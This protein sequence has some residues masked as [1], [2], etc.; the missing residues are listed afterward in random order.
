[1]ERSTNVTE[2]TPE[3]TPETPAPAIDPVVLAV[4]LGTGGPKIALVSLGGSI[5]GSVYR[6]VEPK[7]AA[8]GTAVQNP[9][10][11]WTAVT[12]GAAELTRSHPDATAALVAV[13]VT[14][15]WGSTVPVDDHG[16]AV[17]DCMLW[18]DTRGADL[19]AKQVGGRLAV[20]GLGP[21][22]AASWIRR[23]AGVP[24]TEGNDPLG[25]RLYIAEHQ[26]ELYEQTHAFVEP[27]DYL[28]A[29][30]TGRVAA[31][32]L[33][34]ALSWLTDNRGEEAGYDDRLVKLSGTPLSKLP[35]MLPMGSIVGTVL[36]EVTEA[37][38]LPKDLPVLTAIPDLHAVTLGSGA[39]GNYEGHVSISTSA[40]IGCHAPAKK[41]SILK[42][43]ATVPAA[44]PGRYV[45]ANNHDTAGV[46]L[47]WVKGVLIDADDGL[48]SPTV[49]S[50]TELVNAAAT[51]EP[52][53][54]GVLFAPW[55]NGE[56]SPV[57]DANLRGGFHGLSLATTRCDLVR[58]VLEGVA[59][60]A[61]WLL[62][63]S[64]AFLGES[65]GELRGVGGG[66]VS[67]LWCQIHADVMNRP[68]HRIEQ[69][70]MATVRGAALFAGMS[71]GLIG[72]DDIAS[73]VPV[74]RVF[75]PDPATRRVYD[76]M[77]AEFVKLHKLEG[78]M[79]SRLAKLR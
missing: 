34:M 45:L 19:A 56:R 37:M 64:E 74:E 69:P 61:R 7:V 15:Q 38:G 40:W 29:R 54:G 75:R 60:N 79:Y 24:S 42:M 66:A 28:N 16:N 26:K 6:R 49:E 71:L 22:K 78:K 39:V 63:A 31:S 51:A 57:A 32:R 58:S 11:W 33:S 25:H 10:Q 30:F 41:T 17:G 67:D 20:E 13:A 59:H 55:L 73:S 2:A 12:D 48:T 52:G 43:M 77:Y 18:M 21:T 5:V 62:E 46:C 8:D 50:F 1:M 68:I 27:L 70:L 47:E 3:R 35:P 44:L 36:P 14:G 9:D 4:D 65:F 76:G 53:S 23:S 72:E